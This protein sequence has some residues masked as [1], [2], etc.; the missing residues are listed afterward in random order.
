MSTIRS[1]EVAITKEFSGADPVWTNA[2]IY[3]LT[4]G[5]TQLTIPALG[6]TKY[7]AR[8]RK[9]D[10][11]GNFSSWSTHTEHTTLAGDDS[12]SATSATAA[13]Q[14]TAVENSA[15]T[16]V[17]DSD[18]L[19][20][21]DGAL[22][23]E[24]EFG[25]TQLTASGFEGSWS[26]FLQL[27]LYNGLLTSGVVGTIPN[28]RTVAL[29]YWTLSNVAGSPVAAFQSGGGVRISFNAL[30][31]EKKLVSDPFKIIGGTD[32]PMIVIEWEWNFAN[33][34]LGEIELEAQIEYSTDDTFASVSGGSVL[35]DGALELFGDTGEDR[36]VLV[37]AG[38]LHTWARLV[39]TV[40]EIAGHNAANWLQLNKIGVRYVPYWLGDFY[41]GEPDAAISLTRSMDPAFNVDANMTID[42]YIAGMDPVVTN[43]SASGTWTDD[44]LCRYIIVEVW[45]GGGAGGSCQST[46]GSESSVAGGGGGGGYARKMVT[47]AELDAAADNSFT[48]TV[49]AAGAAAA[50][51]NNTGGTGGTS[52]FANSGFTTIQATGGAGGNG[53]AANN[54]P[55]RNS[56]GAAGVGSG[57]DIN[58]TGQDGD[59]GTVVR[60]DGGQGDP[61][62]LG[63]GGSAAAGGGGGGASASSGNGTA[64]NAYGGGGAGGWNANS[65]ASGRT[66]GAGAAGR[67]VVTKFYGP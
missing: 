8:Y 64:G 18:G 56:G 15:A 43:F 36:S 24:D 25:N 42:G 34:S 66:G 28:G 29:P 19:H 27:G 17:I 35:T 60:G 57:G 33:G 41:A 67:V 63:G 53:S 1:V 13:D 9:Q 16:V 52:S 39:I 12:L 26:E 45:G 6:S 46:T 37:D 62:A 2:T 21:F 31:A 54:G 32:Q 48:V 65:Q 20:I 5:A 22:F 14:A 30:N 23:I 3:L 38:A 61:G 11:Y 49:G 10:V 47:R 7:A 40:K 51:G 50:A 44:G 59:A 55:E 4:E 58:M